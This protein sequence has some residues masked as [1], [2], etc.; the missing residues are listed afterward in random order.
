MEVRLDKWVDGCRG[1]KNLLKGL[2]FY[3]TKVVE[4]EKQ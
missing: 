2:L 3:R 1:M 4:Q